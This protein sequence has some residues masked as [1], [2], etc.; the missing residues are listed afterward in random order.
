[1]I[2][3]LARY[4]GLRCPSEVLPLTWDDIDFE[5]GLIHVR[6]CKTEGYEGKERRIVPMFPELKGVLL[7]A[8]EQAAEGAE[9]VI[10]THRMLCGNYRT[11]ILRII[12]RAGLVAWPKPFHNLRSSR[13][14][15]LAELYPIH[16]VCAWMGNSAMVAMH[17][18]LQVTDAHVARA[19]APAGPTLAAVGGGT[20]PPRANVPPT[21]RAWRSREPKPGPVTPRDPPT[22][23]GNRMRRKLRRTQRRKLRRSNQ[24]QGAAPGCN[25]CSKSLR[26]AG[27]CRSVLLG[28]ARC[29]KRK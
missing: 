5:K 16:V 27:L 7:E 8:F 10:A 21:A 11:Q 29:R 6:S 1:M 12:K 15:E 9:F 23:S 18:Y 2:V 26:V 20:E 22:P 17:H 14:T 24:P 28:A 13:Q 25:A 3:S 4:G 19:I